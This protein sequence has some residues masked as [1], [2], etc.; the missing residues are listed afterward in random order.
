MTGRLATRLVNT[1]AN[2]DTYA[3][4]LEFFFSLFGE[5]TTDANPRHTFAF[6]GNEDEREKFRPPLFV[7]SV[8]SVAC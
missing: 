6:L 1:T 5:L 3:S 8:S 4:R 7:N 2:V